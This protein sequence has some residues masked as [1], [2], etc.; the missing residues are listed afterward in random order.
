M[1]YRNWLRIFI[2]LNG[3]I[4]FRYTLLLILLWY[5]RTIVIFTFLSSNVR[6][7]LWA[8]SMWRNCELSEECVCTKRIGCEW[9]S[10]VWFSNFIPLEQSPWYMTVGLFASSICGNVGESCNG[11]QNH[12]LLH[13]T[14]VRT[15]QLW[16]L[17]VWV[18]TV[19]VRCDSVSST[20]HS[21]TK[22]FAYQITNITDRP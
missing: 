16:L 14:S 12:N 17:H 13:N 9:V 1:S 15:M 22:E 7:L 2:F 19:S 18:C 5:I 20:H 3:T 4:L 8:E 11:K 6:R 10:V 21:I